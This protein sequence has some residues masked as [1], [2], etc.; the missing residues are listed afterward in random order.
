MNW[1]SRSRISVSISEGRWS[2]DNFSLSRLR[3]RNGIGEKIDEEGERRGRWSLV[4]RER[5]EGKI[6]E[7]GERREVGVGI[8]PSLACMKPHDQP[9]HNL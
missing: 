5:E 2:T 9:T 8:G 6:G 3:M 4:R 7:E 1:S